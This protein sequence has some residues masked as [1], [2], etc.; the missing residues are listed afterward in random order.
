MAYLTK[1]ISNINKTFN[2]HITAA[3]AFVN[4]HIKGK[5]D[6]IKRHSSTVCTSVTRPASPRRLRRGEG[7]TDD[8]LGTGRGLGFGRSFRR[9]VGLPTLHSLWSPSSGHCDQLTC[10]RDRPTLSL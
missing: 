8:M 10:L 4:E 2:I 5:R 9:S 3:A 6:N 7:E 1:L